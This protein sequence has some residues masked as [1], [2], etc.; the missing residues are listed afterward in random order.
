MGGLP[1]ASMHAG[2]TSP[3][4][5]RKFLIV[6]RAFYPGNSPRANRTTELAKELCRQ[7]HQVTV[8]TPYHA[9]QAALSAEFGMDFLDLGSGRCPEIPI[10]WR[11]E[12]RLVLRAIRRLL[13]K[14]FAY[15][16][17]ETSLRILQRVPADRNY[18][19]IIS[20]AAPHAVHWGVAWWLERNR[21]CGA[22][23]IADC[24][25]PFMGQENDS[26]SPAFYF[27]W[28]E[29]AF[30]RRADWI[31]VPTEG[32]KDGYYPEFRGKL[33]VIPQGFRFEEYESLRS[34]PQLTDGVTRFAYAGLLIPGRRDPRKLLA[35]LVN[36]D[37]P[38]EFHL[39]TK[40]RA[41]VEP[42]A[43]QDS[44]IILHDVIPREELLP[45]LA[46]MDFLLNIENA[47]QKQ[48]PS[49]LIDYWL[50]GRPILSIRSFEFDKAGVERFLRKDYTGA[51]EI[52]EP[53]QYRIEN[54]AAGFIKLTDRAVFRT[55]EMH[56]GQHD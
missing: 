14:F 18:H 11:G 37:E 33:Q 39:F 42:Y 23:W 45:R 3:V 52:D 17:I 29:K 51:L 6:S 34:I 35:F 1:C 19:C 24:G 7:G 27:R 48:T 36:Q 56:V 28:V 26:F 22:T 41:P 50:C 54:V 38:F 21:G 31:T 30:C 46:A 40:S 43:E 5:R 12:T 44:R 16:E 2:T 15:P 55:D 4:V 9:P 53:D 13:W 20:I 32:A 25:D 47:G 8:L 10:L 49:K